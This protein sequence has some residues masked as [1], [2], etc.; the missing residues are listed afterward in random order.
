MCVLQGCSELEPEGVEGRGCW[1]WHCVECGLCAEDSAWWGGGRNMSG[2][3]V[4]WE[5]CLLRVALCGLP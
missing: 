2:F 5:S 3:M 1:G 4:S